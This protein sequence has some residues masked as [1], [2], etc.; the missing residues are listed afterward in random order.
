M[1]QSE[2]VHLLPP[3]SRS[4]TRFTRKSIKIGFC[5]SSKAVWVIMVWH[6]AVLLGYK[7]V[8][9]PDSYVQLEIDSSVTD[10]SI[11]LFS[12]IAVFSPFIGLLADI[13][14]SRYKTVLCSTYF[15]L[16]QIT[17]VLIVVIVIAV[18]LLLKQYK[19]HVP[20][21]VKIAAFSAVGIMVIAY[22]VFYINGFHFAMDQLLNSSTDD[23]IKFIHWYVWVNYLCVLIT[24][25]MWN[26]TLYGSRYYY[27]NY[28]VMHIVGLCMSVL[29][30]L[31]AI[32]LLVISLC[33]AKRRKVWFLLEP[34][35]VNPYTLLAR[36]IK[37][38]Y[39]HKVPLRRSAFTYC[40]DEPP[41]RLDL[42]KQKYG[43]PFT[44]RQ[45]EDVKAFL[46][47]LKV[48]LTASPVF[49]LHIV[50][51]TLLPSFAR[52]NNVFVSYQDNHKQE[53]YLEGAARRIMI[54]NGLLSPCL[55]V[56][57][58]PLYLS[59]IRPWI[60]FH[61]PKSLNRIGIAMALLVLSL[62]FSFGMDFAVHQ[63]KTGYEHC[64][65]EK[66]SKSNFTRLEPFSDTLDSPLMF[67]S[68]YFF[69]PQHI[70]S[71]LANMLL[72]I[73]VLEFI[74][75]QSPY[76][77]KGLVLGLSFSLRNLFQILAFAFIVPFGLYWKE[78]YPLSCGSGFYLMNVLLAMLSLCLFMYVARRYK[79]R[80][81]DEPRNE[82][83]YAE[84]YYSYP[85]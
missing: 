83:R 36:V 8:Y 5:I 42:A 25:M 28:I 16:V 49:Y 20:V 12:T 3:P 85:E 22:I 30:P 48:L 23:L 84:D 1:D 38:A 37:F 6:F 13:K 63:K 71:A 64:M 18:T 52:H 58:I 61:I 45:V 77:M 59:L 80:I 33:I 17:A 50:T 79:Y 40:E 73:A 35:S 60:V 70:L 21:S 10:I 69:I 43:D 51:Q 34:P 7:L 81:M 62:L 19:H 76:S 15:I 56:F 24:E 11:V 55:I 75:S 82:Y 44:T 57:I 74:C 72:E 29:T 31:T 9:N 47:I 32:V 67:Q 46:G 39:K 41:S 27:G 26:F 78:S 65:L 54:S 4:T 53:V 68:L 14:L 66:Y 2:A